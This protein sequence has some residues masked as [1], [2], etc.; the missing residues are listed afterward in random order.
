MFF[1][2][3]LAPIARKKTRFDKMS[4]RQPIR[5]HLMKLKQFNHPVYCAICH[6][7]IWYIIFS[8]FF[9]INNLFFFQG[10]TLSR[11]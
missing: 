10:F 11:L 9:F 7:F 6:G 5:G 4:S 1:I 3:N 8:Q 2:L